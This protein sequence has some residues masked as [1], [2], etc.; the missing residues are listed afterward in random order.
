MM[1]RAV[2]ILVLALLGSMGVGS[3]YVNAENAMIYTDKDDYSPGETV[4]IYGSGFNAS[5]SIQITIQQPNGSIDNITTTSDANG[6]FAAY[7]TIDNTDPIGLYTI[8]ASDGTNTASTTFTDAP[9]VG[10]VNVSP[11][12]STVNTGNSTTLTV[13]RGSGGGSGGA[14]S[15][16]L[17]IVGTLP[18]GVTAIFNP[19]TVSFASSDNSKQSTLTIQTSSSTPAGT[20][21]F[22]VKA[23]KLIMIML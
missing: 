17:S 13:K 15:A 16:T 9:K 18:S 1:N 6:N 14:F 7:Y 23:T 20:Y 8:T 11:T 22:Q 2:I 10:S 4:T 19:N 5:A 21:T 12:S 3:A